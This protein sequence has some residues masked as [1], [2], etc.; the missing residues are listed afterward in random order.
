MNYLDNLPDELKTNI[1]KFRL[2]RQLEQI[3]YN[4]I[5]C[6]PKKDINRLTKK[7][8]IDCVIERYIFIKSKYLYLQGRQ[9]YKYFI[10]G[11]FFMNLIV[12]LI[13]HIPNFELP[14]KKVI[15][16]INITLKSPILDGSMLSK[17]KK[18]LNYND[19]DKIIL[20]LLP[21]AED[22]DFLL[23]EYNNLSRE[24]VYNILN[25]FNKKELTDLYKVLN[26]LFNEEK[27][28]Y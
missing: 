26:K 14:K 28:V 13:E 7:D 15:Q 22:D 20:E 1:Y 4:K 10:N 24:N 2:Q 19:L 9:R 8:I 6:S 12:N 27:T 17:Y 3:Y 21:D 16:I 11:Y 25:I 5:K 18:N 23:N